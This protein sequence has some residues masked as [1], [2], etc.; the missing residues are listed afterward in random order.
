MVQEDARLAFLQ[1]V[2]SICHHS[3]E[4]DPFELERLA[5]SC[6]GLWTLAHRDVGHSGLYVEG[7]DES[8]E[9]GEAGG[10]PS[11]GSSAAHARAHAAAD[12]VASAQPADANNA[13]AGVGACGV[14]FADN[15]APQDAAAWRAVEGS[16]QPTSAPAG[17]PSAAGGRGPAAAQAAQ[18]AQAAKRTVRTP[19]PAFAVL[20][21]AS[22]TKVAFLVV[23]GT[24]S[25]GDCMIDAQAM[26]RPLFLPAEPP[27]PAAAA[28][29]AE[30]EA[31]DVSRSS[32]SASLR[33]SSSGSGGSSG[34]G[35][36]GRSKVRYWAHG[37]MAR[38]AA[39]IEA[40]ATPL[41]LQL[42]HQGFRVVLCGHSL[43]GGV[44]TL[45][46]ARLTSKHSSLVGLECVGLGTPPM[47]DPALARRA[48]LAHAHAKQPCFGPRRA[49]CS[50]DST[51]SG[52]VSEDASAASDGAS[53]AREDSWLAACAGTVTTVVNRDDLVCRASAAN[54]RLLVQ[55]LK[56]GDA[57]WQGSF[58]ADKQVPTV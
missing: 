58:A 18:A 12:E 51:S 55:D 11:R 54:A 37:G 9:G 19:L 13:A 53:A 42:A 38:A 21:R 35:S 16:G 32:L 34:S 20:A 7:E 8:D 57:H 40:E 14:E 2:A 1:E 45:L 24:Q 47:V 25:A 31:G 17:G 6:H 49:D 33:R 50:S 29:A 10:G 4:S 22:P 46:H 27:S 15:H 56:A 52:R 23:R 41:L 39:W 43:G 36:G 30:V 28:A 26:P 3:Y 48:R 5:F 44:A